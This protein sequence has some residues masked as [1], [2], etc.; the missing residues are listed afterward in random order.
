[1]LAEVNKAKDFF[2]NKFGEPLSET[3]KVGAYAIPTQTSKGDAFMK[4][5]VSD[6]GLLHCFELF[7]DEELTISWY[8][9]K[10]NGEIIEGQYILKTKK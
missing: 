4:V 2:K 8:T 5:V 1:M 9:H 7:W 3:V 6:T 10:K